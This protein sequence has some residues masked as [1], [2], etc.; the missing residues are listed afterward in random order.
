MALKER[1]LLVVSVTV[2]MM[3]VIGISISIAQQQS[4]STAI[5]FPQ[6]LTLSQAISMLDARHPE[7]LAVASLH[8]DTEAKRIGFGAQYAWQADLALEYRQSDR[9]ATSGHNFIDDSRALLILDKPL[10]S[11][12][13]KRALSTSLDTEVAANNYLAA[14][15]RASVRIVAMQAFFDVIVADYAYAVLDEAM[16][17]KFLAFDR[18]QDRFE[19]YAEIAEIEVRR[20]QTDYLD[21]FSI[22][23]EAAN[24]QRASRLR[25]A[26][27]LNRPDAY[28]DQLVEPDISAYQRDIPDYDEWVQQALRNNAGILAAKQYLKAAEQRLAFLQTANR[29]TL[30]ARFQAAEFRDTSSLR[31]DQFRASLYLD[32]PLRGR[33]LNAS[34]IVSQ[35]AEIV[36]RKAGIQL[37]EG[38]V[39]IESLEL[40]QSLRRL[41]DEIAAAESEL[42]YREL[43]LDKVRL[44]YEMEIRA[45]IGSANTH[46]ASA[47]HRLMKARY[48]SVMA[49][50]RLDALVGNDP[51]NLIN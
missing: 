3:N 17:L 6:I 14:Q 32:I 41:E 1:A 34:E 35:Q 47:L 39:R 28:P 16:T 43:D 30:G 48:D 11:F 46:V 19:K 23:T 9:I 13:R 5:P 4:V 2:M 8:G 42:L 7:L 49:W 24:V 36:R 50:E 21:A 10:T 29:P 18:A 20:L 25:L 22:R 33:R 12:G 37:M 31:R 27:A 15:R 45:Q 40:M 44:Q 38:R 51:V 26:L